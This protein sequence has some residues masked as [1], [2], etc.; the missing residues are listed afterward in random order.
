MD[1]RKST[2]GTVF[3]GFGTA[4]ITPWEGVHLGGAAYGE[5]RPARFVRHKLYAK[6]SV[7]RGANGNTV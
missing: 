4:D 2:A 1:K 7:Y 3:A 5:Y 6:A